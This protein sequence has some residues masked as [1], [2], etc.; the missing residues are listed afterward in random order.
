MNY[1]Y[2]FAGIPRLV[3]EKGAR[4]GEQISFPSGDSIQI[5]KAAGEE[6]VKGA[7][8]SNKVFGDQM[9]FLGWAIDMENALYPERILLFA[10]GVL[11]NSVR[12]SYYIPG[13]VE[14]TGMKAALKSGFIFEMPVEALAGAKELR[15]FAL[16]KSGVAVELKYPAKWIQ[17]VQ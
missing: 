16:S 10:E 8:D 1:L 11:K 15:L 12:T 14:K 2:G 4:G 7:L 13:L 6:R 17:S 3:L 9:M 5:I